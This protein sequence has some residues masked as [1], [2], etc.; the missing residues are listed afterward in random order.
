MDDNP[1]SF[2]ET[3]RGS[4]GKLR[5]RYRNEPDGSSRRLVAPDCSY[6]CGPIARSRRP[7]LIYVYAAISTASGGIGTGEK[8][9]VEAGQVDVFPYSD[10]IVDLASVDLAQASNGA[11]PIFVEISHPWPPN[12]ANALEPATWRLELLVCGDNITAE[13]SFVTLSFDGTWPH[14]E[15]AA[16]WEH[17]VVQ[18]PSSERSRPPVEATRRGQRRSRASPISSEPMPRSSRL[19]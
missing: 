1:P 5:A 13:R 3:T 9:A 4:H 10:R 11:S 7:R 6:A 19:P 15:S 16:I 2:I 17:F 8:G 12:K 18:G 14:P